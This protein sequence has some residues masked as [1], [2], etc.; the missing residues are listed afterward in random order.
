MALKKWVAGGIVILGCAGTIYLAVAEQ[1]KYSALATANVA[2]QQ[3]QYA[4]A[5]LL[6]Q[7]LAEEGW[8]EAQHLLFHVYSAPENN[9]IR[10]TPCSGGRDSAR[11]IAWLMQAVDQGYAPAQAQLGALHNSGYTIVL[12]N[13]EHGVAFSRMAAA[14]RN[15]DAQLELGYAYMRGRG[16]ERNLEQAQSLFQQVAAHDDGR[17]MMALSVLYDEQ[18]QDPERAADWCRRAAMGNHGPSTTLAQLALGRRYISGRGVPQDVAQG[19]FWCGL[20][21]A[22]RGDAGRDEVCGEVAELIPPPQ[23]SQI[24]AQIRN[25]RPGA[26]YRPVRQ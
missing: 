7:P 12:H 21:Q 13:I 6:A 20:S 4:K 24:D 11:A 14:Q 3:G 9:A 2:F 17:G 23:R 26:G 10:P 22:R 18:M 16:V 8:A 25:W 5:C 15:G 1:Q 19:Y